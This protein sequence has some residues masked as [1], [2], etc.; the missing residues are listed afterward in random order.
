LSKKIKT[1][2]IIIASIIV[3]ISVFTITQ[4][5]KKVEVVEKKIDERELS[6]RILNGCGI[7]GL[8][9]EYEDYLTDKFGRYSSTLFKFSEASNTRKS[10][11]NKSMIVVVR[12]FDESETP[13]DLEIL[14][15]RTGIE[16]WTYAIDNV[17]KPDYNFIII[18]GNDFQNIMKQER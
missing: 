15:E 4:K 6:V 7:T 2:L 18:I 13:N 5:Y 10:I 8:A 14:Q 1:F 17:E 11:Y 16:P 12:E 9:R 3:I